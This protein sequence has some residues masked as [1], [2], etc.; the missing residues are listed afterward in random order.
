MPPSD[1]S[2]DA[3]SSHTIGYRPADVLT[4]IEETSYSDYSRKVTRTYSYLHLANFPP[5]PPE[6]VTD[7]SQ[8]ASPRS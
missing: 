8:M 5:R 2:R 1:D 3:C 7:L 4:D 6:Q